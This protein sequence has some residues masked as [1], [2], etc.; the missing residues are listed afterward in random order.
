MRKTY[1]KNIFAIALVGAFLVTGFSFDA[2]GAVIAKKTIGRYVDQVVV[3]GKLLQEISGVSLANLRVY[4]YRNGSFQPIR[5][6][7]DEMTADKGDW[8][9]PEGPVANGELSN[10]KLDTWDKLILMVDDTGDKV[11]KEEWTDGYTKGVE[12]EVVDP[13]NG[14]KGWC[15]LL[16]FASNP[17]AKSALPDYFRFNYETNEEFS[18]YRYVRDIIT[19]DGKRTTYYECFS[20]PKNAGGSGESFV[21]RLKIRPTIKIMFGK[22]TIRLSEEKVAS[23]TIAYKRGPVRINKRLEQYAILPGGI[24]ALRAIT[25]I[26]QCRATA[27]SPVLFQVPFKM[28][29]IVTSFVLRIGTDY[30]KN[31]FGAKIYNSNNTEGLLVDGKMDANE[32][33]F[34]TAFDKWRL[35][36]GPC[37]TFMTRSIPSEEIMKYA[38]VK[39]GYIDDLTAL[40]PPESTPGCIGYLYQDWDISAAPRGK[41][42]M[43]LDFYW[44]P[45]FKKG[46]EV[47]YS[48]YMDHPVKIRV[49]EKEAGNQADLIANV[50]EKYKGGWM[51]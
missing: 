40:D 27:T 12:V 44:I 19:K 51:K 25:D 35:I 36:T 11:S 38:K 31:A 5:F 13:L 47:D 3:D 46:E 45:N 7:L 20:I 2:E 6:Q 8:I 32:R 43:F 18:D 49:G 34:N 9:F 33:N 10:S 14:E 26:I 29:T 30:N 41:Y 15:Y 42:F 28:N 39:M 48:N 17:P 22:V 4:S 21:D 50:G 1:Y 37:G 23:N 16:Y 24:K